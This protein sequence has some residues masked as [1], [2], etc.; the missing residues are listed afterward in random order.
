MNMCTPT[1]TESHMSL[2]P[3]QNKKASL[4]GVT[5]V[6]TN[7]PPFFL[8]RL[9]IQPLNS[10]LESNRF[11]ESNIKDRPGTEVCVNV[12]VCEERSLEK[13]NRKVKN[14]GMLGFVCAAKNVL[15]AWKWGRVWEVLCMDGGSPIV[16]KGSSVWN[17][18]VVCLLH[19][20]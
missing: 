5:V 3:H 10:W 12:C 4:S 1:Y 13:K 17:R 9:S 11:N 2:I 19:F 15:K 18:W 16:T 7:S 6:V 14:L 20:I 8:R